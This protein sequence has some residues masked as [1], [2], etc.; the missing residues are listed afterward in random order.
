M[1]TGSCVDFEFSFI[2][3]IVGALGLMPGLRRRA[4][5]SFVKGTGG[6]KPIGA[7]ACLWFVCCPVLFLFCSCRFLSVVCF[8]RCLLVSVT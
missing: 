8:G 7:L 5:P 3:K 4:N 2:F 6:P 1:T